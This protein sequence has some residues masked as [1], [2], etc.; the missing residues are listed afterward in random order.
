MLDAGE[1]LQIPL[2]NL[3]KLWN[4]ASSRGEEPGNDTRLQVWVVQATCL[5]FKPSSLKGIS[6]S[7]RIRHIWGH[8][9]SHEPSGYFM[10]QSAQSKTVPPCWHEGWQAEQR[11]QG[12]KGPWR[13]DS[14]LP[15][16]IAYSQVIAE[17]HLTPRCLEGACVAHLGCA[18]QA[19][20][21]FLTWQQAW[22]RHFYTHIF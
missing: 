5:C 13:I 20:S 3:P 8:R 1:V 11:G 22:C 14:F 18:R 15:A 10:E 9:D 4:K 17:A 2:E 19:C 6:L 12:L 21:S 7:S 16:K